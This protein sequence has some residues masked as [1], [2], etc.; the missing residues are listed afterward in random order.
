ME[1]GPQRDRLR[2]EKAGDPGW[3]VRVADVLSPLLEGGAAKGGGGRIC[4]TSMARDSLRQ[5][6]GLPSDMPLACRS[7]EREA[8]KRRRQ[9]GLSVL[10][11]IKEK[12]KMARPPRIFNAGPHLVLL[13]YT[14]YFPKSMIFS[15]AVIIFIRRIRLDRL[16]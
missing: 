11:F 2:G 15:S 8:K 4:K 1:P 3:H 5:P 16:K 7:S 12:R 10:A 13:S 14:V 6:C 9:R